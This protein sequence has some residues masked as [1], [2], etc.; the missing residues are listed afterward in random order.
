M[1]RGPVLCADGPSGRP[2]VAAVGRMESG[3][4]DLGERCFGDS[5]PRW[6]FAFVGCRRKN[7]HLWGLGAGLRHIRV[8]DANA[9]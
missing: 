9:I 3:Q 8:A 5:R 1:G 6:W 2:L 7:G 4:A